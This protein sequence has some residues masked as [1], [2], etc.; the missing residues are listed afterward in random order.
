M[1]S[2]TRNFIF[3]EAFIDCGASVDL[4]LDYLSGARPVSV[5]LQGLTV[6]LQGIVGTLGE[7]FWSKKSSFSKISR[8][9]TQLT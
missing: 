4:H 1:D 7:H 3:I 6:C 5:L 9:W 8:L 2:L